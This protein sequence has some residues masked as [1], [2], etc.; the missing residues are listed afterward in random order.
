MYHYAKCPNKSSYTAR[1]LL[2]LAYDTSRIGLPDNE[3]MGCHSAN[4]MCGMIG[5]Y[6]MMG[7]DWY[8]IIAH[9]KKLLCRHHHLVEREMGKVME[10]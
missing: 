2:D 9:F 8:F 7:Q 5:L 1:A 4:Y 10:I 3:D 6:P